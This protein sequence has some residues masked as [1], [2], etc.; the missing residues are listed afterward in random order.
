M[1]RAVDRSTALEARWPAA[2]AILTLL[3]LVVNLPNRV[4]LF[5]RW[6]PYVVVGMMLAAMALVSASRGHPTWIRTERS[7]VL[8]AVG[9]GGLIGIVTLIVVIREMLTPT[10]V[11]I[12]L[13]LLAS[14]VALWC[15]N[16]VSAS[17]LYWQL[18][19]GGPDGRAKGVAAEPDWRFPSDERPDR[20]TQPWVPAY[21]D[22]LFLAFTAATAFSPTDTVPLTARAKMLML[23]QSLLSLVTMVIVAARAVGELGP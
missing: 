11:D 2:L 19:R 6:F 21:V 9:L 3:L 7:I 1:N 14:S 18:D 17:L 4:Q 22:Y 8:A 10:A 23:I 5:P 20:A 13:E 15:T 12:G 16:I